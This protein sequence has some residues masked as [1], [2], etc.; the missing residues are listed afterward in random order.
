MK[1]LLVGVAA[2]VALAAPLGAATASPNV[3]VRVD[4]PEFGIRFGTPR[5]IHHPVYVPQPVY[6]PRPVYVPPP[7]VY[8]PAPRVIVPAPVYYYYPHHWYGDGHRHPSHWRHDRHRHDRHDHRGHR[9]HDG[10]RGRY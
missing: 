1:S 7:V 6:A 3:V 9:D 4:T 5:V 2:V 10:R 8:V